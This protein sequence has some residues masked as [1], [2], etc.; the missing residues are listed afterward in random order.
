MAK[1]THQENT[2]MKTVMVDKSCTQIQHHS[3]EWNNCPFKTMGINAGS[4]LAPWMNWW[5]PQL[6]IHFSCQATAKRL[7]LTSDARGN[8][9]LSPGPLW[10]TRGKNPT[11]T[12]VKALYASAHGGD[13]QRESFQSQVMTPLN[14]TVM[15]SVCSNTPGTIRDQNSTIILVKALDRP[16]GDLN[17]GFFHGP[18]GDLLWSEKTHSN[19]QDDR[20]HWQPK[21]T[22]GLPKDNCHCRQHDN[23]RWKQPDENPQ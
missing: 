16:L 14:P 10:D 23:L 21:V 17:K 4:T 22:H 8:W 19:L 18:E 3:N 9:G 11:C 1:I 15:I 6:E 12:G 7:T 5:F 2:A 13:S 20:C